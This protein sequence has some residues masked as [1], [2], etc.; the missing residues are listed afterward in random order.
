MH[1]S[2]LFDSESISSDESI[3]LDEIDNNKPNQK[4]IQKKKN[5][6]V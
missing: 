2:G 1:T 3:D 4:N 5:G 6:G